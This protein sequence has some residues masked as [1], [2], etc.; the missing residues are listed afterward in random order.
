M[1]LLA[2]I[3]ALRHATEKFPEA[4]DFTLYSD[5]SWVVKTMTDNWK[6]K[7]N[8]DLWEKLTPFLAGKQIWAGKQFLPGKQG[9]LRSYCLS[10]PQ[11]GSRNAKTTLP[12]PMPQ[13]F[14]NR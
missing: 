4:T 3:E 2:V 11:A 12:L 5:S 7:K 1:E 13:K 9:T 14:Q 8:L 10:P 6:R